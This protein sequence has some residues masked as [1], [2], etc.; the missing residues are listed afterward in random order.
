MVYVSLTSAKV[1]RRNPIKRCVRCFQ[2]ALRIVKADEV[3]MHVET[4]EMDGRFL[5]MTVF[6]SKSDMLFFHH[7][8]SLHKKKSKNRKRRRR[9]VHHTYETQQLPTWEEAFVLLEKQREMS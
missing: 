6:E 3:A 4:N 9:R 8:D 1:N 2:E 5:T 7:N